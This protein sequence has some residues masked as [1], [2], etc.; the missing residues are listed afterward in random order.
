VEWVE[1]SEGEWRIQLRQSFE[2]T[3]EHA[4]WIW[5]ANEIQPKIINRDDWWQEADICH[6]RLDPVV[7]PL[8]FAISFEGTWLGARTC[9][10]GWAGFAELIKSSANWQV[11]APWLKWWRIP[12]LHDR[13][14]AVALHTARSVPVQTI[15][16]WGSAFGPLANAS[17]SEEYEDAWRSV[18]RNLFWDWKPQTTE[19]AAMLK[20]LGLLTGEPEADLKHGWAKYEELLAIHPVLFAQLVARGVPALYMDKNESSFFLQKLRSM[21]LEIGYHSSGEQV[22]QALRDWQRRAAEAMAVDDLFVS[23]S[24]LPD[25][26]ELARG[27]LSSDRNLRVAVSNSQ[28]VPK[29]LAAALLQRVIQGETL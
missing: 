16:A 2:L 15:Q 12:L 5:L 23:R 21:I 13:L 26:V 18:A 17:F 25:A 28:A 14:K 29:Y 9:E 4:I 24:L 19:S 6:I 22:A 3:A 8:A 1:R 27:T 11:I 10:M 20:G 7:V